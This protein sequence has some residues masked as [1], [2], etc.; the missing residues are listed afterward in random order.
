[1]KPRDETNQRSNNTDAHQLNLLSVEDARDKDPVLR[2]TCSWPS[3]VLWYSPPTPPEREGNVPEDR[4]A[5]GSSSVGDDLALS[6]VI[7]KS[8][9]VIETEHFQFHDL[10]SHIHL[11][12]GS[13]IDHQLSA[14]MSKLKNWFK[15]AYLKNV[16]RGPGN[17]APNTL[18]ATTCHH[19]FPVIFFRHQHTC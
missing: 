18:V 10:D 5:E 19:P 12:V 7:A 11:G 1:M 16:H 13:M 2:Q 8:S 3:V 6:P 15:H 14:R 4:K 17:E 9:E